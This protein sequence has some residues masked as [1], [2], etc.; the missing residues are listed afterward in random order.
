MGWTWSWRASPPTATPPTP[1]PAPSPPSPPAPWPPPPRRPRRRPPRPPPLR[2]GP[3][4]RTRGGPGRAR[5]QGAVQEGPG[6]GDR[7]LHRRP[8]PLRS[9]TAA[10]G[11]LPL[12][13][14]GDPGTERP[15]DPRRV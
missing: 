14:L 8:R 4:G 1:P 3:N 7:A 12:G 9:A 15:E 10:G 11:P 5:H 6:G 13:R 2:R